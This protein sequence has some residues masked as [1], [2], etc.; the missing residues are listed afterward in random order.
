[1]RTKEEK[2]DRK[3]I[4]LIVG[5][6]NPGVKYENS[7]HN[8]GFKVINKFCKEY[9]LKLSGKRFQ[10]LSAKTDYHANGVI[11]ACPQT[12]M[13]NSGLAVSSLIKYYKVEMENLMIVHDDL[14]LDTGRIKVVRSG[15]AGGHRG[16]GSIIYHLKDKD[17]T[18]TKIGIGRPRYM[19]AIEDFVLKPF[20]ED[21]KKTME[22]VV[23]VTIKAIKSFILYG[24]E[25]TMNNFNSVIIRKGG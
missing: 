8:L 21:Q 17:F 13:N 5:L 20:Y 4:Y 19:E 25:S 2:R 12:F 9:N 7:R 24:V 11:L 23:N 10:S 3:D 1:M 16:V 22:E 6:G 15:G 14:D 18:R